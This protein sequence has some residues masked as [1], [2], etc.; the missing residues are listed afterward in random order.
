MKSTRF[1]C[2]ALMIKSKFK[3]MDAIDQLLVIRVKHKKK[4]SDLNNY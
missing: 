3:T 2:L 1:P 4:H